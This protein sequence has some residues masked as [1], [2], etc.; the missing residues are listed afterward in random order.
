MK[1]DSVDHHL[2][3]KFWQQNMHSLWHAKQYSVNENHLFY[4]DA[5]M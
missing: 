4:G 3:F 2:Q 1:F 5:V